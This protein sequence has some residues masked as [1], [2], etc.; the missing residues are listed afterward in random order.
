M[1]AH[2][3]RRARRLARE[4]AGDA[5]GAGPTGPPRKPSRAGRN[6]P[7]AIAVGVGLGAVIVVSLLTR[8]ELMLG[9]IGVAV[10][11]GVWELRRAL[12]RVRIRVPLVPSAVGG[13]SMLGSAYLRGGEA[14][15]VTLGLTCVGI[16]LW[17][18]AD[19]VLDAARDIAGGFFTAV[20][21]SFLAGFAVLLLAADD[22]AARL[23]VF[24]LVTVLSDVGGYVAGVLL[25]RHPMAPT[26]SPKKS[27]EGF[28]G[29][30]LAC[31]VGGAVAVH[32][33]L[34]GP[35]WAGAVL[36]ACAAV[37]ATVGDLT[38]ST[39]KRDL[40]IKDMSAILPGHGGIMDRLDSLLLVAPVAWALLTVFVP[41]G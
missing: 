20:Y 15:V 6:L 9:V 16:L 31:V 25:G 34:H 5:S 24:I 8:K 39:I 12:S 33:T 19:G 7:A 38:E 29:S 40:G 35:W 1:S 30:V 28:A 36:G 14:L 23:F 18:I 32:Y 21:P 37:A 13:V 27:W 22:G 2:E 4:A 10:I 3:T 26:V 17:R 11:G 41:G